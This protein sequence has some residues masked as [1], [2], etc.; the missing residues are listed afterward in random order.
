MY[1][2]GFSGGFFSSA[3]PNGT[4]DKL[5]PCNVQ[6][7]PQAKYAQIDGL[8]TQVEEKTSS[9]KPLK[10]QLENKTQE[11]DI[12]K[13]ELKKQKE[14][15]QTEVAVLNAELRQN[16]HDNIILRLQNS[17]EKAKKEKA[18]KALELSEK[19][20]ENVTQKC[21]IDRLHARLYRSQWKKNQTLEKE[22]RLKPQMPQSQPK[23]SQ[24]DRDP[25]QSLP[26]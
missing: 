11:V 20:K 24:D 17:L 4:Y 21:E 14:K 2:G 23:R 5:L 8:K 26:H 18:E 3:T 19:E 25:L 22:C 1:P 12:L 15:H 10:Q 7:A 9:A 6:Q 16:E 13:R